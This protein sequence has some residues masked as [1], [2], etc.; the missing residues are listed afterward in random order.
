M[1]KLFISL[2]LITFGVSAQEKLKLNVPNN[3]SIYRVKP[4][5]ID[6]MNNPNTNYYEACKAFR[7]FWEGKVVPSE[8]EGEAMD[9]GKKENIEGKGNKAIPQESEKYVYEYKCF[10]NWERVT[11]NMIDVETGRILTIDEIQAII[12]IERNKK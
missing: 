2:T 8:T 7:L 4:I 10:K 9:I 6:M 3:D 12:N 5:W 11:K 1:Y